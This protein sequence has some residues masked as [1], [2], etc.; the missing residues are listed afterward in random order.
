MTKENLL[1]LNQDVHAALFEPASKSEETAEIYRAEARAL[2]EREPEKAAWM[3]LDSAFT[4]ERDDAQPAVILRDL[5]AAMQLAPDKRWILT[6]VRRL[7]MKSSAYKQALSIIE[8]E[9]ALVDDQNFAAALALEAAYIHWIL[10]E[11]CEEALRW[12]KKVLGG[13]ALQLS[14]LYAAVGICCQQKAFDEA[15]NYAVSLA[16]LLNAPQDRACTYALA[17]NIFWRNGEKSRAIELFDLS[18]QADRAFFYAQLSV[19]VLKEGARL[20]VESS[21]AYETAATLCEASELKSA[22]YFKAATL[23]E[24]VEEEIEKAAKLLENAEKFAADPSF[25]LLRQVE[26]YTELEQHHRAADALRK[27]IKLSPSKKLKAAYTLHLADILQFKM[28]QIQPALDALNAAWALDPE[29]HIAFDRLRAILLL[30]ERWE[31]LH[32][33]YEQYIERA[34]Q[35]QASD[36][37]RIFCAEAAIKANKID[38]AIMVLTQCNDSTERFWRIAPLLE[39][40]G[41]W[42]ALVKILEAYHREARDERTKNAVLLMLADL[43]DYRLNSPQLAL[44]LLQKL[45]QEEAS[46]ALALKRIKILRQ[47]AQHERLAEALLTEAKAT[48]D[49]RERRSW[50][51]EAALIYDREL[52]DADRAR[53]LLEEI[54]ELEPR[55]LPAIEALRILALSQQDWTRLKAANDSWQHAIAEIDTLWQSSAESAWAIEMDERL[56]DAIA[57]YDIMIKQGYSAAWISLRFSSLLR[58]TKRW[59]ELFE[60]YYDLAKESDE[61]ATLYL[62]QAASIVSLRII[63]KPKDV[64]IFSTLFETAPSLL[65]LLLAVNDR[66][67]DQQRDAIISI[68]V[69]GMHKIKASDESM[70]LLQWIHAQALSTQGA[71]TQPLLLYQQCFRQKYG[72]Y[73]RLEIS[74]LVRALNNENYAP[75]LERCATLSNDKTLAIELMREASLRYFW[76]DEDAATQV[77]SQAYRAN[78]D[79]LRTIWQLERF[80]AIANDYNALAQLREKLSQVEILPQARLHTLTTAILPYI[81]AELPEHALRVANEALK[82]NSHSIPALITLAHLAESA[83]DWIGLA[84]IG[85]RLAESCVNMNNRLSYGLWA[86][87][88]WQEKLGLNQQAMAS[89]SLILAHDP[90]CLPAITMA[91]GL[92]HKTKDYTRLSRLYSRAIAAVEPSELQIALL[93]KNAHILEE[94]LRDI[95]AA[96][97]ELAKILAQDPNDVF[98]L[99]KQAQ[100]L[101]AQERWSEG[102]DALEQLADITPHKHEQQEA[103]LQ[104]AAILIEKLAQNDKAKRLLRKHMNSFPNDASALRLLYTIA[105]QENHWTD[106]KNTLQELEK[107]NPNDAIWA[108][109]QFTQIA[110]HAN[111]PH[112]Q[113]RSYEKDAVFAILR[114]RNFF[115]LLCQDYIEHEEMPRLIDACKELLAEESEPQNIAEFKG[116]LA[117]LLVANK[118]YNDALAFLSSVIQDDSNTDWAFLARAQ[119]LFRAGQYQSSASEFRRTLSRNLDLHEAFPPFLE[120]LQILQQKIAYIATSAL[121]QH[122]LDPSAP[123]LKARCINGVPRGFFDLQLL[124]LSAKLVEAERYLR[125]MS[126]HVF[127]LYEKQEPLTPLEHKE[128]AVLRCKILFGQMLD[129]KHFYVAPHN[130][131]TQPAR[132][133]LAKPL[134]LVFD[135]KL[136]SADPC[137][138]DFWA[139]FAMHQA[140]TGAC[141]LNAISDTEC[142]A[143]FNALCQARPDDPHAAILKKSLWKALPRGDRKLF[144]DGVPFIAPNWQELRDALNNRA[145]YIGAV[146]CASPHAAL[147]A[148]PNSRALQHFLVTDNFEKLIKLYWAE[149]Q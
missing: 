67:L 2:Y 7:L 34:P 141:L 82:Y 76:E 14:A 86:A 110:R 13:Q 123:K 11:D 93:H 58:R 109:I 117:A 121:Q 48:T 52:K 61:H 118:Q 107:I 36:S 42:E 91:E 75:W 106:A 145:A 69:E 65:T 28:L 62:F 5:M 24:T 113:R 124:P 71:E 68:L 127:E 95:P 41:H 105:C 35:N 38:E 26:L 72:P 54:I 122:L 96:S 138:F 85:D 126:P 55:F 56:E 29:L 128:H 40:S 92:L 88:N 143:L 79:D 84:K 112:E 116:C 16:P 59:Q 8:R 104:R 12:T 133:L 137:T 57:A 43:L 32:E 115:D 119:A 37:M 77:A 80:A 70:A 9:Y 53:R 73:L 39:Y 130:P 101:C 46:R 120:V 149:N 135:Q 63:E 44:P 108:K 3:L 30:A 60:H 83:E 148:F 64:D 125:L 139:S 147:D 78:P 23:R 140:L 134:S 51:F 1:V 81:D 15:A 4:N 6:A 146:F 25:I 144:K 100:L 99:A 114:H 66:S 74:R 45:P 102:V 33:L 31:E 136:L 18:I 19:S 22:L 21:H 129:V 142:S 90:S 131:N 132:V 47:L 10:L 17:A 20:L 89:L 98:A 103:N 50:L 111:W 27:L 87:Q 49:L 94:L 97:T